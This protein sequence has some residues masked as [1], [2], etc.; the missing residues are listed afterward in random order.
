MSRTYKK[1]TNIATEVMESFLASNANRDASTDAP[2]AMFEVGNEFY[3]ADDGDS[4]NTLVDLVT[5]LRDE[6]LNEF[7]D[8][9]E[10]VIYT[11]KAYD[12]IKSYNWDVIEATQEIA[13]N[14]GLDLAEVNASIIAYF[15]LSDRLSSELSNLQE[16]DVTRDD[17]EALGFDVSDC[18]RDE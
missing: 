4:N 7:C 11:A 2:A 15:I 12:I 13:E 16:E 8:G 5:Y 3:F 17:A 6:R 9:H 1:I 10:S 18:D 14:H